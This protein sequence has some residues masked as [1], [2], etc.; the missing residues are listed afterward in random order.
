MS[1]LETLGIAHTAASLLASAPFKLHTSSPHFWTFLHSDTVGLRTASDVSEEGEPVLDLSMFG[2]GPGYIEH[3]VSLTREDREK[4]DAYKA[5]EILV[6]QLLASSVPRGGDKGKKDDDKNDE[7]FTVASLAALRRMRYHQQAYS[8]PGLVF[9]KAEHGIACG[10]VAGIMVVFSRGLRYG[11][12]KEW[13]RALFVEERLP[14]EEGWVPRSGWRKVG[15]LETLGVWW[16]VKVLS[17]PWGVV[18]GLFS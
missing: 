14:I 12:P 7:V 10:E 11:I 13:M 6:R 16:I 18:G 9:G 2:Q 4:G 15:L 1:A 3:D 17:W 8:N 5:D